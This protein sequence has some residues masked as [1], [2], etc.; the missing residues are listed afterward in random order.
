MTLRDKPLSPNDIRRSLFNLIEAA[1]ELPPI[2][3]SAADAQ[4]SQNPS[5]NHDEAE[6][7]GLALLEVNLLDGLYAG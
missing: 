6:A 5:N 4:Q 2:F 7:S 1:G 3:H